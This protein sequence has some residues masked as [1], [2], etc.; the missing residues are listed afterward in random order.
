L[1]SGKKQEALNFLKR[2]LLIDSSD[3]Q[4]WANYGVTLQDMGVSNAARTSYE[5]AICLNAGVPLL[6]FNLGVCIASLE[7]P[8]AAVMS[9]KRAA[10]L[11][12]VDSLTQT[13]FGN[14]LKL[15]NM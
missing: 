5:K 11:D 10:H 8:V 13:N 3:F 14:S 6:Y 9:Y 12:P 2:A 4:S 15:A 7:S 1:F